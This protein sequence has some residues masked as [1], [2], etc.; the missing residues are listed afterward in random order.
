MKSEF[1]AEI[2]YFVL[3]ATH[4][5]FANHQKFQ[6]KLFWKRLWNVLA[7][8]GDTFYSTFNVQIPTDNWWAR[9]FYN[10][11]PP[12]MSRLPLYQLSKI[13]VFGLNS[14]RKLWL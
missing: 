11:L 10:F 7:T 3:F 14:S 1:F 8:E 12:K 9:E 13:I 6:S 4:A 5:V 2:A